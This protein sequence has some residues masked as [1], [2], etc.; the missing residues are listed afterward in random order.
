MY[1]THKAGTG[2][3]SASILP[4]AEDAGQRISVCS[5]H[6]LITA[7]FVSMLPERVNTA[8][9]KPLEAEQE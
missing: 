7:F 3:G 2:K 8:I 9:M 4:R 5:S 6:A 1:I